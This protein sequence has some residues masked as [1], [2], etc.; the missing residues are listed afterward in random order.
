MPDSGWS[1]LQMVIGILSAFRDFFQGARDKADAD[2]RDY[3]DKEILALERVK[4]EHR[5]L[6]D[7]EEALY[8]D[9]VPDIGNEKRNET[10]AK[11]LKKGLPEDRIVSVLKRALQEAG[12]NVDLRRDKVTKILVRAKEI[13]NRDK[14]S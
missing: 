5:R 4:F 8:L 11:Y 12:Y 9:V 6:K 2:S 3:R 13:L 1:V 14:V 7:L 10:T